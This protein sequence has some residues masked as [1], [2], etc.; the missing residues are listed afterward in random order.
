MASVKRIK[1]DIDYLVSQIMSDCYLTIY[2]HPEKKD[3]IIAIMNKTADLRNKFITAANNPA[4]KNNASLVRKH[5]AALRNEI[6]EGVD[7]MF[8]ALSELCK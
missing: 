1:K 5:Y 7:A 8:T 4:E 2:F 3:E 6:M